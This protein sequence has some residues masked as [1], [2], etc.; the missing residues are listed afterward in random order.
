MATKTK[1]KTTKSKTTDVGMKLEKLIAKKAQIKKRQSQRTTRAR[2]LDSKK[3]AKRV[4]K[5]DRYDLWLAHPERYDIIGVD[6]P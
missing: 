6:T 3:Q 1:K 2:N 5:R 4:V